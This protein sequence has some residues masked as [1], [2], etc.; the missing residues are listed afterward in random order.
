MA[1]V[2]FIDTNTNK[3]ILREGIPVVCVSL[4]IR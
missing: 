4:L 1:Y 2:N 3:T